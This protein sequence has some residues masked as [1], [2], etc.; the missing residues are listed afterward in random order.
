MGLVLIIAAALFTYPILALFFIRLTKNHKKLRKTWIIVLFILSAIILFCI[1]VKIS[2][3]SENF[4]FFLCTIIYLTISVILF[5]AYTVKNIILKITA[6]LTMLMVFGIGYLSSTIGLLGLGFIIADLDADRTIQI[7]DDII[8]RQYNLGN[9]LSD[10]RDARVSVYKL[11]KWLPGI[12]RNIFSRQYQVW[13][14]RRY[15]PSIKGSQNKL[16]TYDF[17]IK[18]NALKHELLI[19]DHTNTN[20]LKLP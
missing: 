14:A 13:N 8:F 19:S 10:N 6:A 17:Q 12:Q 20:V 5:W 9:A 3:V 16:D 18:Y 11:Y 2:T 15:T 1:S 7:S 4:N